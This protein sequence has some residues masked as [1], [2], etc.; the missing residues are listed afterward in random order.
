MTSFAALTAIATPG[1]GPVASDLSSDGAQ[2][3]GHDFSALLA[4]AQDEE[5][6]QSGPNVETSA[7]PPPAPLPLAPLPLTQPVA[8]E[9]HSDAEP[10]SLTGE[11]A[12]S[13]AQ[14]SSLEAQ[15]AE[16]DDIVEDTTLKAEV[17]RF[18]QE[19][20]R[21]LGPT[22]GGQAA[23]IEAIEAQPTVNQ[24]LAATAKETEVRAPIQPVQTAVVEGS[25]TVVK[26]Q[27]H[28]DAKPAVAKVGTGAE[29][30]ST[31]VSANAYDVRV[32]PLNK[33]GQTQ[34]I[35]LDTQ[36]DRQSAAAFQPRAEVQ[37]PTVTPPATAPD[38][39]LPAKV[40]GLKIQDALAQLGEDAALELDVSTKSQSAPTP[41]P[42]TA[43]YQARLTN[44]V[45][46]SLQN[47]P[48]QPVETPRP[49]RAEALGDLAATD[50]N[51]AS[52]SANPDSSAV[53][54]SS[55]ATA[56]QAQLQGQVTGAGQNKFGAPLDP[57]PSA[58]NLPSLEGAEAGQG[59]SAQ[60]EPITT[61]P[62]TLNASPQSGLA[63]ATLETTAQISAQ[64]LRKLEGRS[65]RF[66]MTLTPESLGRVDVSLT[67]EADGQV[68]ARLAFDNPAAASEMRGRV[69]ELRRQL[70]D[71]GLTLNRDNLEFTER[72]PQSGS[73]QGSFD[74]H[75]DR[76]AFTGAARLNQEADLATLPV[77]APWAVSS[78]TPDRVDVK[79]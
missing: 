43:A 73:G 34:A 31:P 62:Q 53:S 12:P 36:A 18:E 13:P 51:A 19:Q 54:S 72:N 56:L 77:P 32:Q 5:E 57:S 39:T 50:E 9:A 70:A 48:T 42:S 44:P 8:A 11:V 74:H 21:P 33:A 46:G 47:L 15:P 28:G 49:L 2:E 75:Q 16:A 41:P 30:Q 24:P 29:I 55:L 68:A 10:H 45:A 66:D 6:A 40:E 71:A 38:K 78:Q 1:L 37:A 27:D 52:P 67:I 23:T 35:G 61:V 60:S 76:R 3:A 79:V 20:S 63:K 59:M 64:I 25:V 65:T 69:D 58:L 26:P 17:S 7:P 22:M 4:R 14:Q